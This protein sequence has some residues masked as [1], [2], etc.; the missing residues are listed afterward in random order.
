M[1]KSGRIGSGF[2]FISPNHLADGWR[3]QV[4]RRTKPVD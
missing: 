1:G 2:A 4:R 3:C